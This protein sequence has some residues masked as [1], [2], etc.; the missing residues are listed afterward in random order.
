MDQTLTRAQAEAV[1]HPAPRLQVLAGA[2]SGKTEV[3]ARRAVRLLGEGTEPSSLVAFTFTEKAASELKTRIEGRAAEAD[4]KYHDLPPVG[5][6]MFVGTTHSWALQS[7][8]DLGGLYETLEGLTEEQE[9]VLLHRTGRRLGVVDLFM[10]ASGKPRDRVSLAQALDVFLRSVEVVHNECLE[11]SV[12]RERSPE[13]STA[14]DRYEWLL[15][16]MRLVP[17]RQM[18]GY[19]IE[20]LRPGGRLRD[21]L[22]GRLRHVLVDEFQDFNPAQ[23]RL[24]GCMAE[25]GAT[26]TVVGDDDQAIYQWRGGDVSLFQAFADNYE[27]AQRSNLGENHRSRPEIVALAR[28][29]VAGLSGRVDKIMDSAREAAPSGAVEVMVGQTAEEE[30]KLIAE[31]IRGLLRQGHALGDIGVLFRSVRTSAPPL[32]RELRDREIP[33]AVV[34]KTSLLARPEMA[35]IAR[36]FV[37]WAGGTWYPNPSFEPEVVTRESLAAEVAILTGCGLRRAEEILMALDRL[38]ERARSE[39]VRDSVVLFNE[40]L[41]TLGLPGKGDR[42]VVA[43]LGLGRMSELLTEFDHAVR[44]AAPREL[45]EWQ[46]GDRRD[47]AAEDVALAGQPQVAERASRAVHS[48]PLTAGSSAAATAPLVLGT[49]QGEIYLMRLRAFLEEFAG[50]AAEETP[51]NLPVVSEAV[52]VMTVHQAKG[53]EFPIVFVPA[54]VEGR[55]PSSLM[56]RRQEWYVPDTLFDRARYEGREDD[57]AR[58]LYVALTRARELLVMSWFMRHRIKQASPS[59]FLT[60]RLRQALAEALSGGQAMPPR[61]TR[62]RGEELP[63]LDFSS[64]VTFSECGYRYWLRHVC[65]YQPP[66]AQELGFGKLLH[67]LIAELAR[68]S[69]GGARPAEGDVD[70]VLAGCFYLPFAGPIPAERLR[71]AARHRTRSYVRDFGSEL[72]RTIRPEARFEVPLANARV[73]GRIDLLLRALAGKEDQVELIDFKTSANRPPSDV[74][75]NQL[76]LYAAAAERLGMEPISLAVHDLDADKGRRIEVSQND[77]ERMAFKERLES[78]VDGIRSGH[79]QP[80]TSITVCRGCDYRSFCRHAPPRARS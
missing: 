3:L 76:R 45:Y 73:K 31:R 4:P 59:R 10:A 39:G 30:A 32:L 29:V 79:F 22:Q 48:A 44:R 6:G 57:E 68:K 41:V 51:D 13:F 26:I 64:L 38:G 33:F 19:A 58:L 7:L 70:P 60:G 49:T 36:I 74:H 18:I 52:Q 17:F 67:H 47:E 21:R 14:L 34:G 35:L 8:Q 46:V 75:V 50:R 66:L 1:E 61:I 56:G 53:L 5:R 9:W 37:Y 80:V 12:I 15:R 55:F 77:R 40:I 16:E 23:D 72:V 54:L 28:N 71:E 20:E 69:M 65:G 42:L 43:E 78:W 63:T 25:L 11:R 62:R 2:G 24:L 27:G